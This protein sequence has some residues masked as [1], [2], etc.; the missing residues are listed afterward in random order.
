MALS[1]IFYLI[2]II[3]MTI[4][5]GQYLRILNNL[6]KLLSSTELMEMIDLERSYFLNLRE[7][8][9]LEY[10]MLLFRPIIRNIDPYHTYLSTMVCALVIDMILILTAVIHVFIY[11]HSTDLLTIWCLIDII[12]LSIFIIIFLIIVV[13]INKLLTD[14]FIKQLKALKKSM[15][16]PSCSDRDRKDTI[17]YLDAVIDH[18]ESASK[19]YAVKLFG[20]VVDQK[21]VLKILISIFTGIG[22]SIVSFI[23]QQ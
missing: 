4:S 13:L 3:T 23:K 11:G 14:D 5:I 8:K 20:F 10:F 22:S 6:K 16:T 17:R 21:L 1:A 2:L 7:S 15:V 12:I 9:N 18:M 19:E